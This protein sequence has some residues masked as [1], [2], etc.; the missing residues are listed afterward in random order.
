MHF[1]GLNVQGEGSEGMCSQPFLCVPNLFTC[2][3]FC[4]PCWN[5]E[6]QGLLQMRQRH[7]RALLA[8]C[9]GAWTPYLPS[10]TCVGLLPYLVCIFYLSS[11]AEETSLGIAEQ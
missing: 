4:P 6:V 10:I 5:Q 8:P 2:C 11:T 3:P 7:A 9:A 1:C